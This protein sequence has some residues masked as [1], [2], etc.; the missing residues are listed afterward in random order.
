MDRRYDTN[1]SRKEQR[2]LPG[3]TVMIPIFFALLTVGGVA[4][5]MADY[6]TREGVGLD[7]IYSEG[8]GAPV[9]TTLE[10]PVLAA[11]SAAR[12]ASTT[13]SAD[14]A[15]PEAIAVV[16]VKPLGVIV[17]TG[18]EAGA[19][20]IAASGDSQ[21]IM[22]QT[23]GTVK[24]VE[25]MLSAPAE[26]LITKPVALER[27]EVIDVV[28]DKGFY[29]K[30]TTGNVSKSIF[31]RL[32]EQPTPEYEGIEGRYDVNE[33][34]VIQVQ[35]IIKAVKSEASIMKMDSMI[36][37]EELDKYAD[38]RVYIHADELHGVEETVPSA[39]KTRMY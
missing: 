10:G 2:L 29:V 16:E 39:R 25:A 27:V 33:G 5:I 22:A 18:G 17:E 30:P 34:D 26:A 15:D 38:D 35:G 13:L 4:W 31:V 12:M 21:V 6:D 36:E 28:G 19:R 3:W 11:G 1:Q 14:P 23:P 37:R 20:G 9:A 32:D 7:G 8:P 24:S